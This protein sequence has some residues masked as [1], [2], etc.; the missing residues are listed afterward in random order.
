MRL[1]SGLQERSRGDKAEK[2]RAA[3]LEAVIDL[4]ALNASKEQ[5][6]WSKSVSSD[7]ESCERVEVH[8]IADLDSKENEP[9][10]PSRARALAPKLHT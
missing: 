7:L 1:S 5:R 6:A 10:Q 9:A 2:A 8:Q 3:N 4:N